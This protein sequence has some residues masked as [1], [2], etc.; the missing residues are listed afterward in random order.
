MERDILIKNLMRFSPHPYVLEIAPNIIRSLLASKLT[1]YG[2][3]GLERSRN[4][5]DKT[6]SISFLK[7]YSCLSSS[8]H[9]SG[10]PFFKNLLRC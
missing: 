1:D 9:V 4:D 2:K 7:E 6:L 10:D 8:V 5:A 3:L